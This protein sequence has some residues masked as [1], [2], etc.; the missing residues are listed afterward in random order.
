MPRKKTIADC[1]NCNIDRYLD[2]V[3]SP[4]DVYVAARALK[5]EPVS[6]ICQYCSV[7]TSSGIA[8]F[9]LKHVGP[10]NLCVMKDREYC[11]LPCAKMFGEVAPT[12]IDRDFAVLQLRAASLFRQLSRVLPAMGD[13]LIDH[14]CGIFNHLPTSMEEADIKWSTVMY[15]NYDIT[16]P[17]EPQME[18][19]IRHMNE[20]LDGCK[21]YILDG[22]SVEQ[23]TDKNK[24]IVP[25]YLNAVRA[26]SGRI[27]Y[28]SVPITTGPRYFEWLKSGGDPADKKA[29]EENVIKPNI[30]AGRKIIN[31]IRES[32]GCAV[33]DPTSFEEGDNEGWTQ[34]DFYVFWDMIVQ[35]MISE[36]IFLDGWNLSTGCSNELLSSLLSGR[37]IY[38]QRHK[39]LDANDAVKM[40]ED[41]L[42]QFHDF[43]LEN[44]GLEKVL[45]K[46][47][48]LAD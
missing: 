16:K 37:P 40:V 8:R 31:S 10:Q 14:G 4:R 19:H 39:P 36:V 34:E 7:R 20:Y 38:D 26:M 13:P 48:K 41:G 5:I 11:R 45:A 43:G 46:L 29:K 18:R 28:A 25:D 24:V 44:P 42:Q 15:Y 27:A 21:K 6:F 1:E 47:R 23:A 9:S 32:I 22:E 3:L 35:N 2:I 12:Q 30:L 33:V 17:F